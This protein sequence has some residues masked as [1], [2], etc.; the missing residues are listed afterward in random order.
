MSFLSSFM[1]TPL[2]LELRGRTWPLA[3]PPDKPTEG[4]SHVALTTSWAAPLPVLSAIVTQEQERKE[5]RFWM[6]LQI[7]S[8]ML[9]M[10]AAL[11]AKDAQMKMIICFHGISMTVSCNR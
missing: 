11:Q 9:T 5:M 3:A 7:L 6:T 1:K 4:L 2:V 10:R 8:G